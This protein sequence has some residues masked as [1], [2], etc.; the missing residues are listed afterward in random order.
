MSNTI[1]YASLDFLNIKI[2][3]AGITY[4]GTEFDT[5]WRIL[6]Y[7]V[8]TSVCVSGAEASGASLLEFP[9]GSTRTF[10]PGTTVLIPRNTRHRFSNSE[11]PHVAAWVHWDVTLPP[12]VDLFGF[13]EIPDLITGENS[14]RIADTCKL[15]ASNQLAGLHDLAEMKSLLYRLAGLVLE[16]GSPKREYSAFYSL[17]LHYLPLLKFIDNHMSEKITLA[18]AAKFYNCSI[19]K[20]QRD[21]SAAFGLS[22]GEFIIRR[23][24]HRATQYLYPQ[25]LTL[26]E[27]AEK[28]GFSDAFAFSKSFK[29]CFGISPR[30]YRRLTHRS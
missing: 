3:D 6:P 10:A 8:L 17:H 19:S 24:L 2:V 25:H 5:N 30:E 9:D 16:M 7:T 11:R 14:R 29:K 20:L 18:A 23:R 26:A 21:F 1:N 15:I 27:I 22:L 4:V 28:V 13:Y 12:D